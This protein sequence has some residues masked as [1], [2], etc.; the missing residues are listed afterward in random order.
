MSAPPSCWDSAFA[1]GSS[2]ATESSPGLKLKDPDDTNLDRI[3]VIK[4]WTKSGQIF[5]KVYDVAIAS[6]SVGD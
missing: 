3:Q 6:S 2:A 5:E 4:G 1:P